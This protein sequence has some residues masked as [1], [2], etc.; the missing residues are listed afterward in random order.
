M[1]MKNLLNQLLSESGSISCMRVMSLLSLC[2]GAFIAIYAEIAEINQ[3]NSALPV[4]SV[5]VGAA[6]GGKA[7]QKYSE[8]SNKKVNRKNDK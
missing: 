5:F 7:W 4:V 8:V 1:Q 6:F 2:V 3:L